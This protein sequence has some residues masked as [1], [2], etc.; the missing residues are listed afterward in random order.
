MSDVDSEA[1]SPT[2]AIADRR[3]VPPSPD[4]PL[5]AVTFLASFLLAISSVIH[6]LLWSERDT[7]PVRPLFVLLGVA[8]AL[9]SM[10]LLRLRTRNVLLAGVAFM[11]AVTVVMAVASIAGTGYHESLPS[12]YA[13]SAVYVHGIAS[14]LMAAAALLARPG[15][16]TEL[17]SR[18]D[19]EP[20]DG[21]ADVTE[22]SGFEPAALAPA[23]HQAEP[24]LIRW[25]ADRPHPV[26]I[27]AEAGLPQR[28]RP[29]VEP[30]VP[31]LMKLLARRKAIGSASS[32]TPAASEALLTPAAESETSADHEPVSLS[33]PPRRAAAV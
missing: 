8:A 26:E 20:E 3:S 10:A 27:G 28:V 31:F 17:P 4:A 19:P 1:P 9:L 25:P 11:A 16:A 7:D 18:L 12:P 6:L 14:V 13:Q 24:K 29:E 32:T 33:W 21:E 23:P 30:G 5:S 15:R 2:A 22:D